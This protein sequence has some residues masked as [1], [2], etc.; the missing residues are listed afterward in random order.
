MPVITKYVVER[1]G[2]E[3][4]TFSSKAEADAYDKLLD[5]SDEL[6]QLLEESQIIDNVQM[7]E[8]LSMHLAENKDSLLIAL[9]AKKKPAPKKISKD[10]PKAN[11]LNETKNL[12]DIVIETDEEAMLNTDD[13]IDMDRDLDEGIIELNDSDEAA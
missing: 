5:V 11:A 9:G 6:Y 13:M 1:N 7:L 8:K 4:M 12:K 10:K 2:V 3:K